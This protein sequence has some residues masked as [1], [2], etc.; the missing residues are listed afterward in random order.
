[1]Y[2]ALK[3]VQGINLKVSPNSKTIV[4]LDLQLY[5]KCM[6]LRSRDEIKE[7]FVFRFGELH[8]VFAFLKVLGKYISCSGLDQVLVDAG[9]YGPTTLG[10]ILDGKHMKRGFEA[11][12]VLYL[13][14][15]KLYYDDLSKQHQWIPT[16]LE[17]TLEKLT[18]EIK[19]SE[20]SAVEVFTNSFSEVKND[21]FFECLQN[22]DKSL[23]Q[24]AAFL[25]NYMKMF[26]LLLLFTRA[27]R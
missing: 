11:H 21:G 12:M 10:Q 5:A 20:E 13:S 15:S 19:T 26:E 7:N 17:D 22:F 1:M 2:T 6:E 9:I 8:V 25:R 23:D 14:L 27:S 16:Q 24:Q 18:T 4:T 3:Q